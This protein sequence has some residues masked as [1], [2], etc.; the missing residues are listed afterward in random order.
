[1]TTCVSH[2]L[3]AIRGLSNASHCPVHPPTPCRIQTNV[4]F[5]CGLIIAFHCYRLQKATAG[6][7][8]LIFRLLNW[9]GPFWH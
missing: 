9:S 8:D 2:R 5:L 7:A 3:I 6:A 1:V 4:T